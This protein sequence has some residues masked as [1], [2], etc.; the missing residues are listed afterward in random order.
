MND[1]LAIATIRRI[2]LELGH[3]LRA[4][5]LFGQLEIWVREPNGELDGQSPLQTIAGPN[6]EARV[7]A[8]L[9]RLVAPL[10]GGLDS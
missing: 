8:H 10:H 6:G 9:Q 4:Q 1:L 5:P 2:L 3:D 7:R